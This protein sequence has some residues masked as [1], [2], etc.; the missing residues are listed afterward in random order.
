M[1]TTLLLL[2]CSLYLHS[3]DFYHQLYENYQQYKEE[4]LKTRRFTHDQIL[5]LITPLEDNELFEVTR[6]G[7]SIEGRSLNLISFGKGDI[8]VLLW[9]QM[10]GDEST[11]TMALFDIIN[12]FKA[13]DFKDQKSEMLSSLRIHFL[14]MLNPDGAQRFTRRNA[15]DIDMNRDAVRLQ[16]PESRTLKRV[17]DSLEADFGFNL[18]DQSTYYNASRTPKSAAISFLAPAYNYQKDVNTVREKSMKLIVYMNAII[19]EF[20]PGHI[21]RYNDDFEPRAFGDNIQKW[22]TSTV[23]IESGGYPGDP[24]KQFLRKLNFV[25]IIAAMQ[26]IASQEYLKSNTADYFEIPE[27]DRKLFDLKLSK[28]SYELLGNTYI[29]DL[30]INTPQIVSDSNKGYYQKG[31]IDDMGDLSTHYGYQSLDASSYTIVPAKVYPDSFATIADVFKSNL[32]SILDQGYGYVVVEQIPEQQKSIALPVHVL[33]KNEVP[34][35]SLHLGANPCFF[36]KKDG[37]LRYLITNGFLV[38]LAQPKANFT[39]ALIYN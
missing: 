14:P 35:F 6:V 11:A 5:P 36:L 7:T 16:A 10:H 29:L 22:G 15:L 30:G 33:A 25:S 21:G 20:A 1:L 28:V 4:S 2:G 31:R 27:N 17:R 39:N 3:Q 26:A 23:L 32:K 37:R 9:S 8:D 18:H 24:D 34:K 13:A 12:F 19:Q 38:D